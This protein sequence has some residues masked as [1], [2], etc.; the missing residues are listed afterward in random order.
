MKT[1]DTSLT[2]DQHE[3]TTT[4]LLELTAYHVMRLLHELEAQRAR[5]AFS[6]A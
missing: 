4:V 6:N 2:D 1:L 5:I 3:K